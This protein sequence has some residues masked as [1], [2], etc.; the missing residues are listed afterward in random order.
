MWPYGFTFATSGATSL[1]QHPFWRE[2]Q[3]YPNNSLTMTFYLLQMNMVWGEIPGAGGGGVGGGVGEDRKTWDFVLELPHI[4]RLCTNPLNVL[5]FRFSQ[6]GGIGPDAQRSLSFLCALKSCDSNSTHRGKTGVLTHSPR[7][8]HLRQ[9][10]SQAQRWLAEAS[11]SH[12]QFLP[13]RGIWCEIKRLSF[14]RRDQ[15]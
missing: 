4:S 6:K 8:G 1:G 3:M 5:S 13:T 7:C 9:I 10:L 15:V 14:G 12:P 2:R 11:I